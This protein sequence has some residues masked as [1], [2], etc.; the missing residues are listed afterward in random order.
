MQTFF[1]IASGWRMHQYDKYFS[2]EKKV[3]PVNN[4]L[5]LSKK[6]KEE[7]IIMI[8]IIF[9]LSQR[10]MKHFRNVND[11]LVLWDSHLLSGKWIHV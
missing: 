2:G 4:N 7:I 1:F 3:Y 9:L 8:F 5:S 10:A 6:I 11:D